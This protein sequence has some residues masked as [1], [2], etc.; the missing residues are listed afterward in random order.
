ML[1]ARSKII[2]Y[3]C[4]S[5]DP[6]NKLILEEIEASSE[7]EASEIFNKNFH[8][9]PLKILGP[10]LKKKAKPVEVTKQ[11]QFTGEIKQAIYNDWKVNAFYLKEP[12]GYAFLV[13]IKSLSDNKNFPKGTIIVPIT[14]L[15][16]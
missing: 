15:R 1:P 14:Q 2:Y 8:I 3:I 9:L 5:T 4:A 11:V 13:F 7:S 12:V 6:S 16:F 10:Y